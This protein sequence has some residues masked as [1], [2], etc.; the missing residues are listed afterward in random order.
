MDAVPKNTQI[1][2]KHVKRLA[3]RDLQTNTTMR[4]H[5][6]RHRA[7]VLKRQMRASVR[8]GRAELEPCT[9]LVGDPRR[10]RPGKRP[11]GPPA[12]R[13]FATWPRDTKTTRCELS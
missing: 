5:L 1:V 9:P 2:A 13:R 6:A 12:I 7:S 8:K 4:H 3:I 11:R 10:G